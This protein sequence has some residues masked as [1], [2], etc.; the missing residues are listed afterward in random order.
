MRELLAKIPLISGLTNLVEWL[1]LLNVLL[2]GIVILLAFRLTH[3]KQRAED[4]ESEI[5]ATIR[6]TIDTE[7]AEQP[8]PRR[9]RS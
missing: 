5:N 4:L 2:T 7:M 1:L 3:Y 9:R 6:K 8:L